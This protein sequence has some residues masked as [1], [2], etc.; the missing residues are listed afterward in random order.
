MKLNN[1]IYEL[2]KTIKNNGLVIIPTD[3]IYGFS[4][5]PTS[6]IAID[7][8]NDLKQRVNKPFIILDT[9]EWRLRTYFKYAFADKVMKELIDNKVW[10]GKLTVI[11]NKC[12]KIDYS[13]LSNIDTI[14]VRYPDNKLIRSLNSELKS[15][16]VSTSINL[17]GEQALNSISEIKGTW[18]DKVDKIYEDGSGSESSSLIIKIDSHEKKIEV[19]RD[20][21][22]KGSKEILLKL[23]KIVKKCQ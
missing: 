14:A 11:A 17:S 23:D 7:R 20:P 3:T 6:K 19:I 10:P 5:L 18:E 15:G 4:C 1:K 16:I 2:G 22:T 9:D 12:G 8:I 13:F 21:K